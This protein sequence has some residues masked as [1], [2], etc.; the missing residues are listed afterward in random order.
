MTVQADGDSRE[1]SP[2]MLK[3]VKKRAIQEWRETENGQAF[4]AD[5]VRAS[6]GER[7]LLAPSWGGWVNAEL[8]CCSRLPYQH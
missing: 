7:R 3:P 4:A 2:V 5:Q 8:S 6:P 1:P